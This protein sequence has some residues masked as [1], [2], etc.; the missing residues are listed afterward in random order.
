M[1]GDRQRHRDLAIVLLAEPAAIL[2]RDADRMGPLF[3]NAR[4]VHD[5]G[6]DGALSL[7]GRQNQLENL[8][9]DRLVRPGRFADQMQKRLM[10]GRDACRRN[11]RRHRLDAL[12]LAGHQQP[13]AII[14]QGLGPIGMPDHFN[15]S[16]DIGGKTRLAGWSREIDIKHRV[17]INES[18]SYQICSRRESPSIL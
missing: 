3:R 15:K 10:F 5:P 12:A 1:I 2:P 9:Q 7:E 13:D 11:N 6:F 8:T 17:S 4:V 14:V 16:L 18:T